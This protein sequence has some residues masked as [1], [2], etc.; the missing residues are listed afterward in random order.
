MTLLSG[1]CKF[2]DCGQSFEKSNKLGLDYIIL[3]IGVFSLIFTSVVLP[4]GTVFGFPIKHISYFICLAGVVAHWMSGKKLNSVLITLFFATG[5]FVLFYVLIGTVGAVTPFGYV[6]LEASGVFTAITVVLLLLSARSLG[7]VS[8]ES[9]IK[10]AF[11]GAF[12]FAIWKVLV[13]LLLVSKVV[14]YENVYFFFMT[15]LGYKPVASGI[16][17]GLV[18]FNF[19][20]YDFVVA[21]FLFLVPAYPQAFK[22]V[23]LWVRSL[24]MLIGIPCLVFAFSRLLFILVATL[25]CYVFLF[26]STFK[27]KLI[28]VAVVMSVL[29][30][31]MPW[32]EGVVDQRFNNISAAKSDNI[33][34]DQVVALIDT[35][36]DSPMIGGGFGYYAKNLIRDPAV[37]FNYEVQWVGFLAK[38]GMFG[39]LFLIGLVAALYISILK[40]F[41]T[42]EHYVLVGVLSIFLIGGFT[43]QY[44]VSSASG[45]FYIV[46]VVMASI[47][48]NRYSQSSP[49]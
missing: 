44:L 25:W 11:Y 30:T 9:I 33:R 28:I 35:W 41:R 17:G 3:R 14:N 22:G 12:V 47:L 7:A 13:V 49:H 45:V 5:M 6:I 8:D 16:Y 20:V 26:K 31:S 23:P 36:S 39:V 27:L 18:R 2:N 19:I 21:L 10:A 37:P 34:L 46:H 29:I 32:L 38:F 15:K 40:G 4:S 48:R 1:K 42:R 43:N 24:F